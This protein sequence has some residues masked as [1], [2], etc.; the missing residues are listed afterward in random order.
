MSYLR[1][2]REAMGHCAV[3]LIIKMLME[4][5]ETARGRRQDAKTKVEKSLLNCK[6][7]QRNRNGRSYHHILS[8]LYLANFKVAHTHPHTQDK[9]EKSLKCPSIDDCLKT[10]RIFTG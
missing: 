1:N 3:T 9:E 4:D 8:S 6:N 2:L 5:S 7:G 10:D